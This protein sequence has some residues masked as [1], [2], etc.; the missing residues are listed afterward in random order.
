MLTGTKNCMSEDTN[1]V[2]AKN[3]VA[4]EEGGITHVVVAS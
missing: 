1:M 2:P 3:K 4:G